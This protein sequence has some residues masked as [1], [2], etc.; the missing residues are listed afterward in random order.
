[1]RKYQV[2][3]IT[4]AI[5]AAIGVIALYLFTAFPGLIP[6]HTIPRH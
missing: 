1:M 5:I 3:I 2:L 6:A 4:L